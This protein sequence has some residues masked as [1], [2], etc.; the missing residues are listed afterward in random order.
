MKKLSIILAM[1]LAMTTFAGCEKEDEKSET[2]KETKVEDKADKKSDKKAEEDSPESIVEAFLDDAF[3]QTLGDYEDYFAEDA[4]AEDDFE[5]FKTMEFATEGVDMIVEA[6]GDELGEEFISAI[7]DALEYEV[8]DVKEDGDTAE[9]TISLK[10]PDFEN[11]EMDEEEMMIEVMGIDPSTATEDEILEWMEENGIDENSTDEDM[12]EIFGQGMV[13]YMIEVMNDADKV[14]EE[15]VY[16][17]VKNDDG[18]WKIKK[19][20]D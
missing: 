19:I 15:V 6:V 4:D 7:Y 17:V 13:D 10:A 18:E 5:A 9:V 1:M 16:T 20:K 11:L 3:A 8:V 14:E 2:K 12:M